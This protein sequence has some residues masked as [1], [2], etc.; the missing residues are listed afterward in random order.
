MKFDMVYKIRNWSLHFRA[1]S[2]IALIEAARA[3]DRNSDLPYSKGDT[4]YDS[5]LETQFGRSVRLHYF[6]LSFT[7]TAFFE[8][9]FTC[10]RH[11]FNRLEFHKSTA[12][13]DRR[14]GRERK[15]AVIWQLGYDKGAARGWGV[16]SGTGV[17][18]KC[19]E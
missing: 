10:V 19:W 15:S 16:L 9:L 17:Q 6:A 1:P 7:P 8:H 2:A 13:V 3:A 11:A 14:P 4:A 5:S 12:A 18:L